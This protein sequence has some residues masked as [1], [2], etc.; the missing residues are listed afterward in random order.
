MYFYDYTAGGRPQE[1][2]V[3]LVEH[4]YYIIEIISLPDDKG[5][6]YSRFLVDFSFRLTIFSM[7]TVTESQPSKRSPRGSAYRTFSRELGCPQGLARTLSRQSLFLTAHPFARVATARRCSSSPQD[8][9]PASGFT[10]RP[11]RRSLYQ[12]VLP[13][14]Q[15]P[16]GLSPPDSWGLPQG[17]QGAGL[18]VIFKEAHC[19]RP[20]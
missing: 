7:S 20:V 9:P 11:V 1:P 16:R 14:P 5:R 19:Y 13:A 2:P 17:D 18:A 15:A 3:E 10:Q 6:D 12:V 8:R 4:P